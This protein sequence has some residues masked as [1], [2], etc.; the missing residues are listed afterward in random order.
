[1]LP[2]RFPD[3]GWMRWAARGAVLEAEVLD[4]EGFRSVLSAAEAERVTGLLLAHKLAGRIEL[5]LVRD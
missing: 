5:E 2:L 1:M 3:G 4:G